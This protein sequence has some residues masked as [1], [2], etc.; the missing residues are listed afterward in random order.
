MICQSGADHNT[1]LNVSL[2]ICKTGAVHIKA[3]R[4]DSVIAKNGKPVTQ[5]FR[6]V[7]A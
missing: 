6:P 7:T 4:K 2:C 3:D 5:I 1:S